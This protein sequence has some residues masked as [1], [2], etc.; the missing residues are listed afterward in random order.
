MNA[1][2]RLYATNVVHSD[3][4]SL[5]HEYIQTVENLFRDLKK[6]H[7]PAIL[8][9]PDYSISF[10]CEISR[11]L[12]VLMLLGFDDYDAEEGNVHL[13]RKQNHQISIREPRSG[14]DPVL[15]VIN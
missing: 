13:L 3:L 10:R 5:D 6:R 14:W 7:L 9:K 4:D 15:Q 12:R 11:V 8:N 2:H 1:L